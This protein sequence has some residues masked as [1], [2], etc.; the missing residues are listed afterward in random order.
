MNLNSL[1]LKL[2]L[3]VTYLVVVSIGLFKFSLSVFLISFKFTPESKLK[4][5]LLNLDLSLP[6]M[7]AHG[8]QEIK[9]YLLNLTNIEECIAKSQQV[10][11]NYAKRQITWWK[12]SELNIDNIFYEFPTNIS[13]KSLNY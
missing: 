2:I 3:G 4:L 8:V 12:S 5:L 1:N 13:L 10:T 9:K 6:I 7:K 11:R